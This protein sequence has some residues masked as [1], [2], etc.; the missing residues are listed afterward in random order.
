MDVA[1]ASAVVAVVVAVVVAALAGCDSATTEAA[2]PAVR[3][4]GFGGPRARSLRVQI[5]QPSEAGP[6]G[7]AAMICFGA[8]TG[9]V[10]VWSRLFTAM[11]APT[12]AA[13]VAAAALQVCLPRRDGGQTKPRPEMEG[14]KSL[15][16]SINLKAMVAVRLS[17][18]PRFWL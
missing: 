16:A 5:R 1:A 8:L 12:T 9:A 14:Q 6:F 10:V 17:E 7:F 15:H 11:V 2:V 13:A 4:L 3:S 18:G